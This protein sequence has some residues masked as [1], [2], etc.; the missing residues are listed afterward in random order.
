[1]RKGRKGGAAEREMGRKGGRRLRGRLRVDAAAME[2]DTRNG[3]GTGASGEF[4]LHS[5]S[6]LLTAS[7]HIGCEALLHRICC[8]HRCQHLRRA[9]IY[10]RCHCCCPSLLRRGR[11]VLRRARRSTGRNRKILACESSTHTVIASAAKGPRIYAFTW[12]VVLSRGLG[13]WST[14]R[15]DVVKGLEPAP[16]LGHGWPQRSAEMRTVVRVRGSIKSERIVPSSIHIPPSS[17]RR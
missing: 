15:D 4:E 13:E 17:Q 2:R 7:S 8:Y 6:H 5:A 16:A 11:Q 14:A 12:T 3:G 9:E 1:M 10:C